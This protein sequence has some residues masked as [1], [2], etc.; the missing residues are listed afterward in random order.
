MR[1]LPCKHLFS[2]VWLCPSHYAVP[3]IR[4]FSPL[5]HLV[6]YVLQQDIT[7]RYY[8]CFFTRSVMVTIRT[9]VVQLRSQIRWAPIHIGLQPLHFIQ[10]TW[11]NEPP[12]DKTNKM[13]CAPSKDSDQPGHPPSLIRVFA[14]CSMGSWGPNVSSC[15]QRMPRLIWVFAGHT[16]HFVD[17]VMR[18]LKWQ[19]AKRNTYS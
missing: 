10:K 1:S 14:V 5:T 18:Q 4:L 2:W 7:L 3:W 16:G 12:R 17:F 9:V 6:N 19:T 13:V 15:G 11:H 8:Q